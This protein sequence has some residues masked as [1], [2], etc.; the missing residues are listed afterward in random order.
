M[1]QSFIERRRVAPEESDVAATILARAFANDPLWCYL[2]PVP[3]ERFFGLRQF[4]RATLPYYIRQ[5]IVW[6]I[7]EPFAG[8]SV[9]VPPQTLPNP[10]GALL[11]PNTATIF[12]NPLLAAFGQA[13]PVFAQFERMHQQYKSQPHYYLATIGVVPQ[14][15]GRGLASRLIKPVLQE[16]DVHRVGVYTETMTASNVPLYQHYGFCV[17]EC[18]Q[19]PNTDLRIWSFY[20][21]ASKAQ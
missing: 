5:E 4:F 15:H 18:Y 19:V 1:T 10:L 3:T 14:A 12:F 17:Q 2:L 7:G 9:W 21:P 13:I 20:R 11:N 6:S 8:I 16:A